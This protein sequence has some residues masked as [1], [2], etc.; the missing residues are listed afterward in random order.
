[1]ESQIYSLI[2]TLKPKGLH[3]IANIGQGH[4]CLREENISFSNITYISN[5]IL[6]LKN[7]H[8]NYLKKINIISLSYDNGIK[9]LTMGFFNER[10]FLSHL[11]EMTEKRPRVLKTIFNYFIAILYS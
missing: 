3:G 10:T 2:W 5:R 9:W 7:T 4:A 1:M 6:P 8:D 11:T